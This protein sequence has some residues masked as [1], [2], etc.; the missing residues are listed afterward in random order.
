MEGYD[1]EFDLHSEAVSAGLPAEYEKMAKENQFYYLAASE[2]AASSV[3][4]REHLD[5]EGH[6]KLADAIYHKLMEISMEG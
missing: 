4:D 1:I 6:E 2:Y 5:E 3:T